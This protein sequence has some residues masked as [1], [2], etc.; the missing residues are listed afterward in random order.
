MRTAL[1]AD[2]RNARTRKGRTG[3][4][5]RAPRLRASVPAHLAIGAPY[6]PRNM[7]RGH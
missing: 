3:G 4:L 1:S 6:T 7:V 2:I 5:R